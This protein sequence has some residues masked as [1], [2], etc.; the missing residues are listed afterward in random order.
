MM[1]NY[2]APEASFRIYPIRGLAGTFHLLYDAGRHEAVLID[3]G[4]WA[5]CL[6]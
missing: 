6:D 2:I 5:K 3:T 1:S 4:W